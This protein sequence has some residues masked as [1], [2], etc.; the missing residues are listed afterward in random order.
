MCVWGAWGWGGGGRGIYR[1]YVVRPLR[2]GFCFLSMFFF[3][4]FDINKVLLIHKNKCLGCNSFIEL[5]PFVIFEEAFWFLL[6]I[7][8][9][10][11]NNF[12]NLFIICTNVDIDKVFLLDKNKGLGI[13]PLELFPFVI[14]ETVIWFLLLILLDNFRNLFRF[15]INVAIDAF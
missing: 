14:L 5:F 13:I 11:L 6:L 1:F 2:F 12:R 8:L 15:C 3:H 4:N 10:L 9:N 7:L